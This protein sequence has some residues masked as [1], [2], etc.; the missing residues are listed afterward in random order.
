MSQERR[1]FKR[2]EQEVENSGALSK[3]EK[4]KGKERDT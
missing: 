4:R 3:G 1:I 2:K